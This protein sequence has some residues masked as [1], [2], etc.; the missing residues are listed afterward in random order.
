MYSSVENSDDENSINS[1]NIDENNNVINA[2][3]GTLNAVNDFGHYI[4]RGSKCPVCGRYIPFL[5]SSGYC[6]LGCAGKDLLR[7]ITSSITGEYKLE[8]PE[9]IDKIRN[10][11][12]Y[13]NLSFNVVS[14][15]PDLLASIATLPDEY[16]IYATAKLN[17]IFLDIKKTINLLLIKKNELI[18]HLLSKIKHGTVEED[19]ANTFTSIGT[20]L[21]TSSAMREKLEESL[22]VAYKAITKASRFFYIGP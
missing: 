20:I 7:K 12:N 14:K 8:T 18:V 5:P 11:M 3:V 19:S 6:S 10:I 21:S 9:I 17:L 13:L 22:S 1:I 16:K 4:T 15:L 2:A